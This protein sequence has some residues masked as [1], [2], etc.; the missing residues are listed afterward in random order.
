MD[1]ARV[2]ALWRR[3]EP[4]HAAVYFAPEGRDQYGAAGLRG[5]WMAYFASRSAPMGPVP[6]EVVTAT[7]YVFH[8][9]MV[10]RAIPD[11][12][13]LSSPEKALAARRAVAGSALRRLL[14]D[15]VDSE[16]VVEAGALARQAT[17]GCNLEGRT[18]HAAHASLPWPEEPH[19]ALW[20]AATLLR[21]HRFDGHVVALAAEELDGCAANITLGASDAATGTFYS[22]QLH[23]FR[24]WSEDDWAGAA[25]RLRERGW[26]DADGRLT[27]L[28]DSGRRRVEERTDRLASGP[29]EALGEAGCERLET[30]M[31]GLCDRIVAGGGF[32]FPNP[33]GLSMSQAV[34]R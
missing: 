13:S 11:A 28:G 21:E 1:P 23:G 34:A 24:G 15:A 31:A 2:R 26:L 22:E 7:F 17:A 8:P 30:L 33:M 3:F 5:G 29:A 20:H 27:E 18:L 6:A 32:P 4:Y 10:A 9:E 19:L 16:T 25:A 14:G 12:W